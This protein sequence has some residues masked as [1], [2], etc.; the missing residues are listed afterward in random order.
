MFFGNTWWFPDIKRLILVIRG[1]HLSRGVDVAFSD[2]PESG[3]GRI[4]F[5]GDDL[6]WE[7]L[8]GVYRSVFREHGYPTTVDFRPVVA[9]LVRNT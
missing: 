8:E 7:E 4:Y 3:K 5:D 9:T 2:F 1:R 6:K